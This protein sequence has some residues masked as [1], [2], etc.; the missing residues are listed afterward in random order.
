[1]GK[2]AEKPIMVCGATTGKGTPCVRRA[3]AGTDH[4]GKGRCALH[5]GKSPGGRQAA[6][7]QEVNGMAVAIKVTPGQAVQGA[8]HSAAGELAYVTAKVA[9]VPE[10]QILVDGVLNP[11]LRLKHHAEERLVKFASA[12]AGMGIAAAQLKIAEAQTALM[13][14]FLEGVMARLDLTPDQRKAVPTAIREELAVVT[15]TA[16]EVS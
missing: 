14:Q 16:S 7:K 8:M 6:F 5:G 13:G 3:G 11:W 2:T 9:A 1:M 15:S 12:A 10:D 4:Y